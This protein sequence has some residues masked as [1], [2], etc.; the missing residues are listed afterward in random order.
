MR[1]LLCHCRHHL[2]AED[3]TALLGIV[4]NH[5]IQEH[6]AIV[7]TDEQVGE[8]IATRT[9]DFEYVLVYASGAAFEEDF[10]PEPFE[11]R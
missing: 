3:D 5:L 8:I 2:E 11:R 9:Y 4:R 6:P 10:G 1:A 7:P